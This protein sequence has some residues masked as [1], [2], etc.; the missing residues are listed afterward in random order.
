M[1]T[2]CKWM[3]VFCKRQLSTCLPIHGWVGGFCKAQKVTLKWLALV[4]KTMRL[5]QAL[6]ERCISAMQMSLFN[7][8]R[9]SWQLACVVVFRLNTL[10][11]LCKDENI[12]RANGV[13]FAQ[14]LLRKIFTRRPRA[15]TA[16]APPNN[17]QSCINAKRVCTVRE[18]YKRPHRL[19]LQALHKRSERL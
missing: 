19:K 8:F 1:Q 18:S 10:C 3:L 17:W 11:E 16:L 5:V 2:L 6:Y 7:A 4:L 13:S 12:S 9:T 14:H 15:C